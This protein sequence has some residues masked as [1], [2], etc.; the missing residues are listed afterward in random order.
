MVDRGDVSSPLVLHSIEQHG[1]RR[2]NYLSLISHIEDKPLYRAIRE[3]VRISSMAEGPGK[4]NRCNEWGAPRVP[5]LTARGG[6]GELHNQQKI[7]VS[8]PRP[9]WTKAITEGIE[10]GTCKRIRYW[11]GQ[12]ND[13]EDLAT[14]QDPQGPTTTKV[15]SRKRL[16]ML[17]PGEE[18]LEQLGPQRTMDQRD[19][20]PCPS[21]GDR[22]STG[23]GAGLGLESGSRTQDQPAPSCQGRASTGAGAG[24]GLESSPR[25]QDPP[26]PSCEGKAN[27]KGRPTTTKGGT[28]LTPGERTNNGDVPGTKGQTQD[29]TM[30]EAGAG[31]RGGLE[32]GSRTQDTPAP[33][34]GGGAR[35]GDQ[36]NPIPTTHDERKT[37]VEEGLEVKDW[38]QVPIDNNLGDGA[39]SKVPTIDQEGPTHRTE[40]RV[41][42][43]STDV[44][45]RKA[46]IMD[47]GPTQAATLRRP[48]GRP[49]G[50]RGSSR[51]AP[52]RSDQTRA[53][54]CQGSQRPSRGK[55]SRGS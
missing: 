21:L 7:T 45:L 17:G 27:D 33:G 1:G 9:A 10:R 15:P 11:T 50:S 28:N 4:L 23:N 14:S 3:S 46:A 26:A 47:Q 8:N 36:Q 42:Y 19:H 54:G 30:T 51:G 12:D 35:S 34:T 39:G 20:T 16:R 29:R 2:P 52:D 40:A 24:G 13:V 18:P 44:R 22:A 53:A 6:D 41:T 43:G 38:T 48:R 31:A 32:S 37:R 55:G 5:V 49:A 25:T